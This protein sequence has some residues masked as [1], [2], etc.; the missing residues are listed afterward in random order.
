MP[1]FDFPKTALGG[2]FMPDE[3]GRFYKVAFQNHDG[4]IVGM[5]TIQ[6][7]KRADILSVDSAG[8][9]KILNVDALSSEV[10]ELFENDPVVVTAVA[11][12]QT[13]NVIYMG[14]KSGA[15]WGSNLE[16]S[17]EINYRHDGQVTAIAAF[18]S[19]II[20]VGAD[21]NIKMFHVPKGQVVATVHCSNEIGLLKMLPS[22]RGGPVAI[23]DVLGNVSVWSP[24]RLSGKGVENSIQSVCNMN[25]RPVSLDTVQMFERTCLL[26]VTG[27]W[28]RIWAVSIIEDGAEVI[29]ILR[30]PIYSLVRSI[31]APELTQ[32]TSCCNTSTEAVATLL[33]GCSDG[34]VYQWHALSGARLRKYIITPNVN[35]FLVHIPNRYL[36][37]ACDNS[38]DLNIIDPNSSALIDRTD[39]IED[40]T[41]GALCDF[42]GVI[43]VVGAAGILHIRNGDTQISS[44]SARRIDTGAISALSIMALESSENIVIVAGFITGI[45]YS[46]IGLVEDDFVFDHFAMKELRIYKS[47]VT[48]IRSFGN[49]DLVATS[50]ELESTI[51]WKA[52]DKGLVKLIE[53]ANTIYTTCITSSPLGFIAIGTEDGTLALYNCKTWKPIATKTNAHQEEGIRSIGI[54]FDPVKN[55]R[56]LV[57]VGKR[58]RSVKTWKQQGASL[59]FENRIDLP[60]NCSDVLFWEKGE[61]SLMFIQTNSK[62]SYCMDMMN[63][64]RGPLRYFSVNGGQLLSVSGNSSPVVLT[65]G[66]GED[67]TRGNVVNIWNNDLHDEQVAHNNM[68]N[69][70]NALSLDPTGPKTT[71]YAAVKSHPSYPGCLLDT[72]PHHGD[73]TLLARAVMCKLSDFLATFLPQVPVVV[74][75]KFLFRGQYRTLLWMAVKMKDTSSIDCILRVWNDILTSP[76]SSIEESA[77]HASDLF[78][79][80]K[81]LSRENPAKF[82][83]FIQ[84]LSIPMNHSITYQGCDSKDIIGE[85]IWMRGSALRVIPQ[86]WAQVSTAF[87]DLQGRLFEPDKESSVS[88]VEMPHEDPNLREPFTKTFEPGQIKTHP[89]VNGDLQGKL[90]IEESE[91]DMTGVEGKLG[92]QNSFALKKRFLSSGGSVVQSYIHPIPYAAAGVEF[93]QICQSCCSSSGRQTLMASP[94]V[95]TVIEYKWKTFFGD[96]HVGAAMHYMYVLILYSVCVVYF[97]AMIDAPIK[98]G[99][100]ILAWIGFIFV[101]VSYVFLLIQEFLQLPRE[102]LSAFDSWFG[103]GIVGYCLAVSGI[104]M[105]LVEGETSFNSRCVLAIACL[106]LYLKFLNFLL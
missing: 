78:E 32:F 23:A 12:N 76:P 49:E 36:F 3:R 88:C 7:E 84:H 65:L 44:R 80:L 21:N 38:N 74:L 53:L 59:V 86:F 4:N 52:S 100:P 71:L 39:T 105:T 66:F 48:V 98:T 83:D 87:P 55:S 69:E 9:L 89:S 70:F 45:I 47:R 93:L 61:S 8:G 72:D 31:E 51:I 22:I 99:L 41:C 102:G 94:A 81:M 85:E 42:R 15:I 54:F 25:G 20:S 90:V 82:A 50:S 75:Q 10:L 62:F 64:Q 91:W 56:N 11:L 34:S 33:T 77:W 28:I 6:D 1:R 35:T 95:S 103:V 68:L 5:F 63:P 46:Y 43:T 106:F 27:A 37:A 16:S 92:S 29:S 97:D 60:S 13:T 19:V 17:E 73:Q 67:G 79:D 26:C 96:M 101:G 24:H 14:M 2:N 57:S 40:I 18:K 58:C 104:T 30:D